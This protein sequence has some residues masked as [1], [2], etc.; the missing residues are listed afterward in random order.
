MDNQRYKIKYT[1]RYFMLSYVP[2]DLVLIITVFRQGRMVI[3]SVLLGKFRFEYF[4]YGKST[5]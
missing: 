1:I 5:P 3:L 4:T 2:M